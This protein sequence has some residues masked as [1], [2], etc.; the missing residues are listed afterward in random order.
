ME[1]L[2]QKLNSMEFT[3]DKFERLEKRLSFGLNVRTKGSAPKVIYQSKKNVTVEIRVI[4][5][6]QAEIIAPNHRQ[7]Q[8]LRANVSR[9]Q[10]TTELWMRNTETNEIYN[11]KHGYSTVSEIN[12]EDVIFVDTDG[13]VDLK[14][15]YETRYKEMAEI[16]KSFN[17]FDPNEL[18][19]NEVIL[20]REI[21]FMHL[22][23]FNDCEHV[24][25]D[26]LEALDGS[27][28]GMMTY[29]KKGE[30]EDCYDYD[31]NSMYPY[32]MSESNMLIPVGKPKVVHCDYECNDFELEISELIVNETHKYFAQTKDA[33]GFYNTYQI[34]LLGI[35][36]IPFKY[37]TKTKLVYDKC[38]KSKD[39]FKYMTKL[40]ELKQNGNKYVKSVMSST[41]GALSRKKLFQVKFEDLKDSQLDKIYQLRPDKGYAIMKC[42]NDRPYKHMI[43]RMKTFLLAY[44]RMYMCDDILLELKR[45]GYEVYKVLCDGF[46]TNANPEQMDKIYTI[47]DKMGELK[48]VEKFEGK[49]QLVNLKKIEKCNDDLDDYDDFD[50]KNDDQEWAEKKEKLQTKPKPKKSSAFDIFDKFENVD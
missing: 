39:V 46:I 22:R 18:Y 43:G 28:K 44:A 15:A 16:V 11:K 33:R 2:K 30:I 29:C 38:I 47:G 32:L 42:N 31:L 40:Y 5:K 25:M 41:W 12:Y 35:L 48:F 6:T 24:D 13:K 49:H 27:V 1:L 4:N 34:R 21:A 7:W 37:A 17:Y 23:M 45:Y 50:D 20:A 36:K 8:T 10:E 9:M 19:M 3:A 14:T 26:E